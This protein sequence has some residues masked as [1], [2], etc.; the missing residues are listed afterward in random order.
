[1]ATK[2]DLARHGAHT[3]SQ[4]LG[5]RGKHI[6]VNSGPAWSTQRTPGQSELSN[7]TLSHACGGGGVVGVEKK[8]KQTKNP[9]MVKP[10]T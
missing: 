6:S 5:E 8:L 2:W 9:K 3:E 10:N 7:K 1:M 4:H